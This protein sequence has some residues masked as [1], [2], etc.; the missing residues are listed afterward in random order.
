MVLK[1]LPVLNVKVEGSFS[2]MKRVKTDLQN[3]LGEETLSSL[4]RIAIDGPG[5]GHFNPFPAVNLH[6]ADKSRRGCEN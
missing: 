5:K 6:L 4:M 2:L 1:L 3:Q